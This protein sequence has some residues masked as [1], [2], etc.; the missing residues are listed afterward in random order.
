MIVSFIFGYK[1]CQEKGSKRGLRPFFLP[2]DPDNS[3]RFAAFLQKQLVFYR[4]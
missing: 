3:G 2:F 1:K 4:F